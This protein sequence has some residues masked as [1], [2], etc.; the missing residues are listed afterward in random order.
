ML[1]IE[2]IRKDP[3]YVIKALESRGE[4]NPLGE[5]LELDARRRQ[6]IS[7]GDELRSERNQVS[8]RIGQ[9]RASGQEPPPATVEEMRQ[10]GRRILRPGGVMAHMEVPVRYKDMALYDQ[11][12]RGWQT[13]YNAE[14]FWDAACSTDLVALAQK[15][16]LRRARDGYLKRTMDPVREPRR[17]L[18]T[19]NQGNDDR[20]LLT[21][22]K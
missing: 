3:D 15:A 21:A 9:L 11:V 13:H 18:K 8:R 10:G 5:L 12:M 2:L 20:D 16:G 19:A 14:P 22:V 6:G 17:L 7:R 1:S 4:E